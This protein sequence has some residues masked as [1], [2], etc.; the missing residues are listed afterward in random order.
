MIFQPKFAFKNGQNGTMFYIIVV[1]LQEGSK[2]VVQSRRAKVLSLLLVLRRTIANEISFKGSLTTIFI[3]LAV[4][5][6]YINQFFSI[7]QSIFS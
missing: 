7:K 1:A 3:L 6:R 2:T 5:L 4:N